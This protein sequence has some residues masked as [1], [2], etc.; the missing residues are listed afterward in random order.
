MPQVTVMSVVTLVQSNKFEEA[1]RLIYNQPIAIACDLVAKSVDLLSKE[2]WAALQKTLHV[3][4]THT[5]ITFRANPDGLGG[6]VGHV[7]QEA[8]G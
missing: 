6:V 2:E 4:T 8:N 1:A 7:S 3:P 5:L